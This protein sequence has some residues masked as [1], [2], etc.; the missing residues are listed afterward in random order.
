MSSKQQN[1]LQEI[2]SNLFC[3]E[4]PAEKL[5]VQRYILL[6]AMTIVYFFGAR[7][8]NLLFGKAKQLAKQ[9]CLPSCINLESKYQK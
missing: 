6:R 5:F 4:F 7:Q 3:L 8:N 1:N 2:I 9:N